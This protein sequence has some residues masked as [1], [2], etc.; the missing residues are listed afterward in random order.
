[1]GGHSSDGVGA[2]QTRGVAP[3]IGRG[4]DGA[5]DSEPRVSAIVV[6][7]RVR[8]LLGRCLET[9]FAQRGVRLEVHVVDNA[10]DDGSADWVESHFP[11]AHLIRNPSNVGFARANNQALQVAT[12]E[13]FA[14]V[15][16]DTELPPNALREA[17][18]VWSRYPGAGAVG[19]ALDSADG[20]PQPSC[21][22]FPG[23]WNVAFES[24]GLH[25]A[26][27]RLGYGS[28]TAA[29]LPRSGEGI[30]DWVSGA[31]MILSRHARDVVGELDERLFM[32]GEE[33]DW[34]W[35][36]RARGFSTVYSSAARVVH[37][38]GASG[39]GQRGTLF[40]KNLEARLAFLKRHRGAWRA[41]IVRELSVAG[42][43]L[44]LAAWSVRG[45][46]GGGSDEP[47]R[48]DQ[49]ERFR[50]VLAWRRGASH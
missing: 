43:A 41:A 19:L 49:I 15:N 39:D 16:P 18:G 11:H 38:G 34:S 46:T 2:G 6:S 24:L 47:R 32:Y 26:L 36:A 4:A 42:A 3:G 12:G 5:G 7:Y 13:F 27:L 23:V 20:S 30:V 21:H 14:L 31:C 8:D 17:V 1:M 22:A 35:R 9:L 50:A 37:H 45:W 48:R 40:V 28:P 25:R 33:M 44:R 29:P 10:S